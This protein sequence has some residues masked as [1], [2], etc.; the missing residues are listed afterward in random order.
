M[1]LKTIP[2]HV[3]GAFSAS[4]KFILYGGNLPDIKKSKAA[5][6]LYKCQI[7]GIQFADIL[8]LILPTPSACHDAETLR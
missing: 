3:I 7:P 5:A 2:G 4:L 6:N 1:C 8:Q